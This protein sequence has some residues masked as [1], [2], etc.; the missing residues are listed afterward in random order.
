MAFTGAFTFACDS[1]VTNGSNQAG[2][3]EADAAT[4]SEPSV[5]AAPAVTRIGRVF[6]TG[7][8]GL[9]M[10]SAPSTDTEVVS[11]LEE[12]ERVDIVTGPTDGWYQVNYEG[13]SGF[14]SELFIRE[15]DPEAIY[16]G[17]QNLLPFAPDTGW[18]VTQAHGGFSHN[19]DYGYWAWDFGTPVGTPLFATH[20]GEVRLA[21]GDQGTGCCDVS[22]APNANYVVI[23]KGDGTESNFVHLSA[24]TVSAGQQVT[25]GD[26]V[27]YTG[28]SGY[29]CG[30]HLHFQVQQSP[31]GGGGTGFAN[32]TLPSV[33]H[34]T[35][36]PLDPTLGT[37]PISKNGILVLP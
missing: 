29:V 6:G 22:C 13:Q 17:L 37:T 9:N 34:D 20:D 2:D 33:F 35:G 18:V 21:R 3:A 11:L 5:D 23:D 4:S 25:R 7:N 36:E 31:A 26:L 15:L 24:V 8:I 19:G 14:A 27:G 10:R 30:A 28:E 16:G 12:G 32:V 1:N